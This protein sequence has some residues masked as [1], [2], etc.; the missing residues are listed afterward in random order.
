MHRVYTGCISPISAIVA[1]APL[2]ARTMSCSTQR[3]CELVECVA[4][5]GGGIKDDEAAWTIPLQAIRRWFTSFP[6]ESIFTDSLLRIHWTKAEL[7]PEPSGPITMPPEM[8]SPSHMRSGGI[9]LN[10]GERLNNSDMS[11][12]IFTYVTCCADHPMQ[13]HHCCMGITYILNNEE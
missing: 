1:Q 8:P 9:G 6:C 10:A 12:A 2:H 5:T 3:V 13:Y 4:V 7:K 11:V